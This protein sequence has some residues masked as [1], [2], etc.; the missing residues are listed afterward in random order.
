MSSQKTCSRVLFSAVWLASSLVLSSSGQTP[1]Q[2][3]RPQQPEFLRQGQQ[4]MR[5]GKLDEALALYKE[6]LK[7]SPDS[8]PANIAAGNVLDVMGKGEEARTHFEKAMDSADTPERKAMAQRA[9]AM[10]YAFDSNCTE[11][12]VYEQKVFDYYASVHD[13]YQQGEMADEGARVCL[14]SDDLRNTYPAEHVA[15]SAD[16]YQKGHEVGLQEPDI[17][18]ERVDLWN[19]RWENAQARIAARRGNRAEAEKHVA[20]AKAIFDRGKIPEQAPFVPY[21]EGYVAFFL[22][23]YKTALDDF[24]KAN[25]N[26]AFVQCLLG[27]TYER[28]G[29]RSNA[30]A[31]Y[32]KAAAAVSHNPPAAYAVPFSKRR[33]AALEEQPK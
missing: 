5:Q 24:L 13:S 32:R 21:L 20:A 17:K 33:L 15:L 26:D 8:F 23:D 7:S 1:P 25:P 19:F 27:R 9:M 31:S 2:S 22:R 16:W 28:L 6:T 18:P 12:I 3:P 4:L 30:I 14:D 11:T 29:D 10:S